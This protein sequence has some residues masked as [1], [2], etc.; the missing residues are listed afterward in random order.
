MALML[1]HLVDQVHEMIM[2]IVNHQLHPTNLDDE[3]IV[4]P[5]ATSIV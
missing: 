4:H 3:S 2:Q 5:S 1:V